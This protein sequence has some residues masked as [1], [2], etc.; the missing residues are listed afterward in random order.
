MQ[1]VLLIIRTHTN[2]GRGGS[3]V[4]THAET[5]ITHLVSEFLLWFLRVSDRQSTFAYWQHVDIIAQLNSTVA[6]L[7]GCEHYF[8]HGVKSKKYACP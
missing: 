5:L 6:R 1:G 2:L 8:L 4:G 7:F 3:I